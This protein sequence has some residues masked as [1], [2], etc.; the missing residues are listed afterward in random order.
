MLLSACGPT[1]FPGRSRPHVLHLVSH[2][3]RHL[4]WHLDVTTSGKTNAT[5][6]SIASLEQTWNTRP[7]PPPAAPEFWV[8]ATCSVWVASSRLPRPPLQAGPG[9]H[10]PK[11]LLF[12]KG[13]TLGDWRQLLSPT[14]FSFDLTLWSVWSYPSSSNFL[15]E[16]HTFF[17]WNHTWQV[18][19]I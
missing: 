12:L 16:F 15:I 19:P 4:I 2:L 13:L 14:L 18:K 1:M 11:S 7:P 5:S 9:W 10:H 8:W 6:D 3:L 17:N